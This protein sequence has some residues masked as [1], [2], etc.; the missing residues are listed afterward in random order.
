MVTD[1]PLMI[2]VSGVR[3]IVGRSLTADVVTKWA[4]AFGSLCKPGPVVVGGDSRVSKVMMRAATFAGLAGSGANIIDVGIVSTPTVGLAVEYH[5]AAGGIAITA[6]HNPVEW[7]ALKFYN[8]EG[9]FLSE[10]EGAKLRALAEADRRFD[11]PA[12]E[13]GKYEKDEQA[14]TRHIAAA[15]AIPFLKV[16]ELR[17]R[18]FR[19]GLDCVNGAGGEM[20]TKLLHELGCE[21]AGFHLEPTGL[22]PRNPE[23]IPEHLRDVGAA[24]REA[25]V[26]IGFVVDPDADRLAVL[27]ET[28]E[29]A[30]EELTVCAASDL[31][32]RYKKGPVV[33]NC[34]TTRA[35]DDVAACYGVPVYRTKVGEAHVAR[36]MI[37]TGATV[38][39][40]GN[41]G[42]MLPSVHA[43]RDTAV[44]I[45]L[46]LQAVLEARKSASGYFG[47]LPR[48]H[49]I[50]R[51]AD[52]ADLE[53]L[54]HALTTVETKLPFGTPDRLDGLK[55]TMPD[56]WVQVRAS[57]TE[58]I[59]RVFAE[60]PE[61]KVAEDLVAQV[62]RALEVSADRLPE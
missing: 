38:G 54:K 8:R 29:P 62:L 12:V 28:G 34:S 4:A 43:A 35:I 49:M 45:P 23:P 31:V 11:V 30:G 24:M 15:L 6:S 56:A 41:G 26:D 36:K 1:A 20:L 57:N 13:V 22:F 27:L 39:G 55:W 32:L 50:K 5:K 7:N 46:I 51:R 3:G 40:E 47:S 60:A 16:K 25:R 10:A 61:K 58:P 59:A 44:G 21:I 2:S 52:F 18:R 48:Y 9:L 19:V 33:V 37:E 17:V 42:V 14:I 53:K